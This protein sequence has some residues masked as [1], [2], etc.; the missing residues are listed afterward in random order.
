MMS[1]RQSRRA[2]SRATA[3]S[4]GRP[5]GG[6]V[7]RQAYRPH[8][9]GPAPHVAVRRGMLA[10]MA[11]WTADRGRRSSDPQAL[12]RFEQATRWPWDWADTRPFEKHQNMTNGAE[13]GV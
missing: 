6:P 9:V 7:G 3:P 4:A 10:A 5:A 13:A 1:R 12:R 11:G 8:L 2:C